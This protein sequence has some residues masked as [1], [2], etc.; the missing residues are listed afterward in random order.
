MGKEDKETRQ[1]LLGAFH[2][3]GQRLSCFPRTS[4]WCWPIPPTAAPCTCA[5]FTESE[6]QAA[7]RRP[8]WPPCVR[9]R[10]RRAPGRNFR[11]CT[12]RSVRR[13]EAGAR[14]PRRGR[15]RTASAADCIHRPN[16]RRTR[17][18]SGL[19][20]LNKRDRGPEEL[21]LSL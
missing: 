6:Y 2:L 8:R 9:A 11:A 16:I 5:S 10:Q 12:R 3:D 14:I 7:G 1:M 19:R 21:H 18:S 13:T 17:R 15:A 20:S 4:G